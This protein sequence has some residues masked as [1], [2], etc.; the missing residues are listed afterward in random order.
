MSESNDE[1]DDRNLAQQYADRYGGSDHD[2]SLLSEDAEAEYPGPGAPSV[3]SPDDADRE[4]AGLFWV[5]VLVFN[6]AVGALAI[7]PMMI[8]FQGWWDMGLQVTLV[9]VLAFAYGTIRYYRF[10]RDRL[11][12]EE[13]NG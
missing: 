5:L 1:G 3:P 11:A 10:R 6:L 8:V 12:D 2:F 7:G 13:R 4:V 9:G